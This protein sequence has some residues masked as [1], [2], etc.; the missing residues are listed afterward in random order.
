[1][2]KNLE[3]RSSRSFSSKAPKTATDHHRRFFMVNKSAII[4]SIGLV[5]LKLI[6]LFTGL[7][8]LAGTLYITFKV[9][10]SGSISN[11]NMVLVFGL[12][13]ITIAVMYAG[14]YGFVRLVRDTERRKVNTS[15]S[16]R[17]SK[18]GAA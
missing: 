9:L 10:K 16:S 14:L 4:D 18:K 3:N 5:L 13:C 12:A 17:S 6:Y 1:M 7:T 8:G 11:F 2:R 15:H